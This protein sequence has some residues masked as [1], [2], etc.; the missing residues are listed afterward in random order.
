M[1]GRRVAVITRSRWMLAPVACALALIGAAVV[2]FDRRHTQGVGSPPAVSWIL[3][4]LAALALFLA[5]A[6]P[7]SLV[8]ATSFVRGL[9]S[10]PGRRAGAAKSCA[11]PTRRSSSAPTSW[12][13]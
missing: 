6:N 10:A 8:P 11:A 2:E 9:T 13:C 7:K 3:F 4:G 1:V 5:V 12:R